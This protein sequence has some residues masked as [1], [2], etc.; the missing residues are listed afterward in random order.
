MIKK[1]KWKGRE[2]EVMIEVTRGKRREWG[3]TKKGESRKLKGKY[4]REWEGMI[5]KEKRKERERES[6]IKEKRK[7]KGEV[8]KGK[9]E[10][11]V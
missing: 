11:G 4:G 3:G 5:K 6:W 8:T 9:E 2:W 7:R 1:G 10:N